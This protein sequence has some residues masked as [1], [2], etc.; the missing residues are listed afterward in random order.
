MVQ[1]KKM[2]VRWIEKRG[3]FPRFLGTGTRKRWGGRVKLCLCPNMTGVND[4]FI[5]AP[6]K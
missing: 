5:G 1:K 4:Y 2:K 3:K 6:T